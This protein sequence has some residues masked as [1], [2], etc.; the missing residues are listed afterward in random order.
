[1]KTLNLIQALALMSVFAMSGLAQAQD[2]QN[3]ISDLTI[4]HKKTVKSAPKNR[5]PLQDEKTI[6]R[7][8]KAQVLSKEI[9][10]EID[11]AAKGGKVYTPHSD[12]AYYGG[13]WKPSPPTMDGIPVGNIP[14]YIPDDFDKDAYQGDEIVTL[15]KETIRDCRNNAPGP[16]ILCYETQI[17][18]IMA[19][20]GE[21]DNQRLLRFTLN[22]AVDVVHHV[23]PFAGRN[24]DAVAGLMDNFYETMLTQA[25]SFVNDKRKLCSNLDEDYGVSSKENHPD[26]LD[27]SVA[28][29]GRLFVQE[30]YQLA[31]STNIT[32]RAKAV[33]LMRA[34][35]Y[36]GWDLSSDLEWR[37]APIRQLMSAVYKLQNSDDYDKLLSEIENNEPKL[38]TL[39]NF[40]N[41]LAIIMEDLS[42]KLRKA[43]VP[44]LDP[45]TKAAAENIGTDKSTTN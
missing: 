44:S 15:I 37:E 1:M 6:L 30:M 36:L 3:I 25:V 26:P 10:E 28:E 4:S 27:V 24:S 11:E 18:T 40:L 12:V 38:S 35:G 29:F 22:R 9:K 34:T 39:N 17:S 43:G 31:Q 32:E 2:T 20:S 13:W 8:L 21:D 5:I 16:R 41:K 45:D 19:V 7:S 33:L 42:P 14:R 23:L